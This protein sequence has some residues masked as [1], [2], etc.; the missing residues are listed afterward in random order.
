MPLIQEL[1]RRNVFKVSAAYLA[2]GWVITQVTATVAPFL[3]LPEW[4]VPLV[5]WVGVIGFPCVV[6]F[7]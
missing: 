5:V 6:L 2:L 3:R 4:T 7:S 1:Q